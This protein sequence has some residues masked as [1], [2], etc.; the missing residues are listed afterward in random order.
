MRIG[1]LTVVNIK[2]SEAWHLVILHVGITVF[3]ELAKSI[4]RVQGLKIEAAD[5]SKASIMYRITW[6]YIQEE[7]NNVKVNY[8]KKTTDNIFSRYGRQL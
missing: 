6:V 8:F 3:K 2:V 7:H 5:D 1:V 4:F